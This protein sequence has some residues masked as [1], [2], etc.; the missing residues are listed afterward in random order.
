[1][2]RCKRQV[3]PGRKQTIEKL[4]RQTTTTKIMKKKK[5][6]KKKKKDTKDSGSTKWFFYFSV[7]FVSK[8]KMC[9][10]LYKQKS[11]CKSGCSATGNQITDNLLIRRV[12]RSLVGRLPVAEADLK[13]GLVCCAPTYPP[14]LALPHVRPAKIQIFAQSDQTL[15]WSQIA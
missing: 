4:K 8:L 12:S 2:R 15:N 5:K 3:S 6:K 14:K 9:N 13:K 1:M 10:L 7:L 11:R